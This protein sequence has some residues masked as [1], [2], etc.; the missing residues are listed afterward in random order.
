MQYTRRLVTGIATFV[1]GVRLLSERTT[2]SMHSAR[3]C[4]W[5]W[6]RH[7]VAARDSGLPTQ[8]PTVVELGPGDSLGTGLAALLTGTEHYYASDLISYA[9]PEHNLRI[10][11]EL[12]GLLR[13]RT[14]IPEGDFAPR[15]LPSRDFPTDILTEERLDAAL[16]AERLDAIRRAVQNR[17][18]EHAG[19]KVEY[20]PSW[21]A[22]DRQ[23]R[24]VFSHAVMEHV[25]DFESAYRAMHRT[26]TPGGVSSHQIDFRSHNFARDWNGHW[27]FNDAEWRLIR[28]RRRYALNR[29]PLHEH[30][31]ALERA[32]FRIVRVHRVTNESRLDTNAFAERFRS[33]PPE[34]VTTRGALIQAVKPSDLT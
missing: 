3:Y 4:Y 11:D 18:V 15:L 9:R 32:G 5:V 20:Q 13:N 26:L 25:D 7:L 23:P 29:A 21:D 14:P 2:G 28:G 19:I 30:A 33:M 27:T 6:L 31:A 8:F 17:G 34:D 22:F 1:P 12:V 24:L 16:V 10:L